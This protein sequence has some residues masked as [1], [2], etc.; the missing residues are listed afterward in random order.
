MVKVYVLRSPSGQFYVGLTKDLKRRM[1]EHARR[2]SPSTRRL[3][4]ELEL[5]LVEEHGSYAEARRREVWLK[6]GAGGRWLG[7]ASGRG[8]P[9]ALP[10]LGP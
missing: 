2:Q 7:E 8:T 1:A 6:S 10:R 3:V 4:G 5:F 9:Q